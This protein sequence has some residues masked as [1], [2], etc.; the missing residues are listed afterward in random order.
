M[1]SN[2]EAP[3]GMFV[4]G[5]KQM[6][7]DTLPAG[8]AFMMTLKCHL[9]HIYLF[10]TGVWGIEWGWGFWDLLN[11]FSVTVKWKPDSD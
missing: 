11:D 5:A 9:F 3:G 4:K 8:L 2:R 7:S 6:A 1:K 10:L